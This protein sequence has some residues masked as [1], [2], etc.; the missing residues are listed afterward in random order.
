MVGNSKWD[1]YFLRICKAASRL[2]KD[3]STKLGAVIVGPDKEIRSTGYN[4]FPRGI[5]DDWPPRQRRPEKYFFFEHAERNAIYNAARVGV[6]LKGSILYCKW[7][8]CAECARACIQ[9]GIIEIVYEELPVR[10]EWESSFSAARQMLDE[11][12]IKLRRAM[13][14]NIEIP[15]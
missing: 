14:S 8:P 3:E 4:S 11:A 1:D 12:G 15:T 13:R 10:P 6:P 9:V 7:P 5:D 2:S